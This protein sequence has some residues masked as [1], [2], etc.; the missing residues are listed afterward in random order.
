[1]N[2]PFC[3]TQILPGGSVCT[4]CQ[5][6]LSSQAKPYL[7]I[8]AVIGLFYFWYEAFTHLSIVGLVLTELVPGWTHFGNTHPDIGIFA[9]FVG[10]VVVPWAALAIAFHNM[11]ILRK[12]IWV[13]RFG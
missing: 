8:L 12:T 13:R 10:I 11:P 7:V 4:G 2:C 1:M 6:Y 9:V 3:G 5:A